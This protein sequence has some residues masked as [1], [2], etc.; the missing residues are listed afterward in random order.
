L[1]IR[2]IHNKKEYEELI[3]EIKEHDRLYYQECAPIIS[4]YEYDLLLKALEQ[5]EKEHLEHISPTSPTKRV[6]EAPSKGFIQGKH[7]TPMMSL[8]NTYSKDEIVDFIERVYKLVNKK[9]V[10]FCAELKMDGTAISVRYE[11][12]LFVRALTR[13]DGINGDDVTMNV[14]TIRSVPLELSGKNIPDILEV[15]GEVFMSK[16]A[17]V[18]INMQRQEEGLEVWANP[19]NA[20]A[21][22][23]KLLD[24]KEVA[25]RKLDIIFYA[26]AEGEKY[27]QSQLKLHEYL[28]ELGLNVGSEKHYTKCENIDEIMQFVEKI[29]KEREH[30]PFEIDGIVIKVDDLNL[31]EA[32]GSTGKSP[33]YATAY[34]FA[35]ERAITRINDITVQVGRTG[36]LTPVAELEPVHLAGSTISRATLHNQDEIDRKDIRIGDYVVIEKGGDVIPKVVEVDKHG[37]QEKWHMPTNCPICNTKTIHIPE[38]VAVRCPNLDCKGRKLRHLIFFASKNAMDIEHLGEKV[39]EKLFLAGFLASPSDIYLLDEE[40]LKQIEGFKDK[41]ITNLL[42]SIDKSKKCD[43]AKFIMGL[44]IKYVGK[45]TAELIADHIETIEDVFSITKEKLLQME[46]IGDKTAQSIIDYFQNNDNI[47]EI[48]LLLKYGVTPANSTKKKIKD[49][50]FNN[51]TFVL[52]GTLHGFTRD[53]ASKLIKE[54]GGYTVSS[55]SSKTDFLLMGDEA[56]SK[57]DKAKSLGVKI[58]T[59]EDFVKML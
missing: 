57:Y 48:K 27:V 13:G 36:V 9:D 52:T 34:K 38:E 6:G 43:L 14:K 7:L 15:R 56:G 22:S 12:G 47:E 46:G 10:V 39:V 16:K 58:I 26:I 53:E 40:K 20:A 5:Y 3:R 51:K 28:K 44:E 17:F 35:P 4:D 31:Y 21:G 55:V 50:I 32:L 25:K 23:L 11:K 37:G 33:R 1:K 24:P 49:H 45:E 59:E 29:R 41:S 42:T 8:A 54:R 2:E 19:R 18:D 30:L